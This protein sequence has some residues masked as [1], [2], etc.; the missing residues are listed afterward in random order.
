[1]KKIYFTALV[2]GTTIAAKAQVYDVGS[3]AQVV[4]ISNTGIAVGN[5]YGSGQKM[6]DCKNLEKLL[7]QAPQEMSQF[8]QMVL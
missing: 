2:L 6:K 8:L 1:M 4:D 7:T 3:Y 5:I